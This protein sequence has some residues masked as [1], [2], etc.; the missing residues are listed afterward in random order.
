MAIPMS[1]SPIANVVASPELG[2]ACGMSV[3]SLSE[4]QSS[5]IHCCFW[6]L[7]ID[8]GLA[9]DWPWGRGGEVGGAREGEPRFAQRSCARGGR[10]G[11]S[12]LRQGGDGRGRRAMGDLRPAGGWG[13]RVRGR[14]CCWAGL[15]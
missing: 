13:G 7:E 6:D 9:G 14:V 15:L 2:A 10:E 1:A 8:T 12:R 11:L 5:Y 4:A 3:S